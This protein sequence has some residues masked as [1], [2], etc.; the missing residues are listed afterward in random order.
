MVFVD[1]TKMVSWMVCIGWNNAK[2][3]VSHTLPE[4]DDLF[5]N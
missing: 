2:L 3:R 4:L 1:E 5:F